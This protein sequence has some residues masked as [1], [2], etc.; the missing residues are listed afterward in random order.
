MPWAD[1]ERIYTTKLPLDSK[2]IPKNL[3]E[4]LTSNVRASSTSP[5]SNEFSSQMCKSEPQGFFL[6]CKIWRSFVSF[7]F[8]RLW[9]VSFLFIF[10]QIHAC[11]VS[12]ALPAGL[13]VVLT[14]GFYFAFAVFFCCFLENKYA[15]ARRG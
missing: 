7:F 5:W 6:S 9:W 12:I 11:V 2:E 13:A 8:T 1:R 15:M 4:R 3:H 14:W 10:A